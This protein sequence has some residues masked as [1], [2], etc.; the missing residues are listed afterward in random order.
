MAMGSLL[1]GACASIDESF[2]SSKAQ[3]DTR[4]SVNHQRQKE[5]ELNRQK[6][7]LMLGGPRDLSGLQLSSDQQELL[8]KTYLVQGSDGEALEI[9]ITPAQYAYFQSQRIYRAFCFLTLED[10]KNSENQLRQ[11][12]TP[13]VQVIKD[14]ALAI[15]RDLTV[16]EEKAQ[17]LLNWV[18]ENIRYDQ[19]EVDSRKNYFRF[20]VETLMEGAGDCEDTSILYASLCKAIGLNVVLL[21][22]LGHICT[23]VEGNFT[24]LS[25]LHDGRSYFLAETTTDK[26]APIGADL[27]IE[28]RGIVIEL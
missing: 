20:P 16:P 1:L 21:R 15:T 3:P 11:F 18:C 9:C 24:G 5:E 22:Q 17:A 28:L 14:L 10:T 25:F 6:F 26:A 7:E 13:D 4:A 27:G 8:K 19:V 12:V 2:L 23:A